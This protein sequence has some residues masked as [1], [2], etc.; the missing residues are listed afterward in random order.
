MFHLLCQP[1]A[2]PFTN[3]RT[4]HVVIIDPSLVARVIRW[5]DV[6]TLHLASVVRQ[7]R[8]ER[9]KVVA[10]NNEIAATWV[11]TGKFRHVFE[12]VKGDLL[13]M[14]DDGFFADP[15]Q[16][17]HGVTCSLVGCDFSLKFLQEADILEALRHVG[18]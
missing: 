11:T 14:V 15:I 12:Q 18:V 17:W 13:M 3:D 4:V 2:E 6:D 10:L 16:R 5:I 7:Q 1:L 8:L 9:N